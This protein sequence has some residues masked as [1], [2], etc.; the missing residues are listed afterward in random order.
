MLLISKGVGG[1]PD[2][3]IWLHVHHIVSDHNTY[4]D[5]EGVGMMRLFRYMYTI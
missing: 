4:F 1:E 3:G 2:E 5:L